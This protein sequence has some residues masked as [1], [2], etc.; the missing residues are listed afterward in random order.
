[1]SSKLEND[2]NWHLAQIERLQ[3]AIAKGEPT[4]A[5]VVKTPVW[6]PKRGG[7]AD[8]APTLAGMRQQLERYEQTLSELEEQRGRGE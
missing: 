1:M 6:G 4:K 2:I 7:A 3:A 8:L 5:S